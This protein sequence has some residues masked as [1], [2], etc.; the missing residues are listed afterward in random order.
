MSAQDDRQ[1]LE[2]LVDTAQQAL[3]AKEQKATVDLPYTAPDRRPNP[4]V[5]TLDWIRSGMFIA[6]AILLLTTVLVFSASAMG[7]AP[8][9]LLSVSRVQHYMWPAVAVLLLVSSLCAL[10]PSQLSARR[11][12]AVGIYASIMAATMGCA[13]T[14]AA[15]FMPWAAVVLAALSCLAG[16]WGI[17]VLNHNTARSTRERL[18]TDAPVSLCTGFSLVFTAHLYFAAAGWNDQSHVIK[19]LVALLVLSIIASVAAHSERGRHA[20]ALGFVIGTVSN[21]LG[22]WFDEAGPWWLSIVS[23][24]CGLVVVLAAENRRHQI[25]HAEHRAARGLPVVN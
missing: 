5:E 6:A 2:F 7:R 21:A 9:D 8:A 11:Q 1:Q 4:P 19:A 14:L 20:F 3:S 10:L 13:L 12:R 17:R 16:L 23:V 18:M 15:S 24:L 25:T 22:L